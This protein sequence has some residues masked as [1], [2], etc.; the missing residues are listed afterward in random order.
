M[1]TQ[2]ARYNVFCDVRIFWTNATAESSDG[3]KDNAF[4]KACLRLLFSMWELRFDKF[5]MCTKN[6]SMASVWI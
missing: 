5:S 3:M 1:L 2:N 6:L 4:V